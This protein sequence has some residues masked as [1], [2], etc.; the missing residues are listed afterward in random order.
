MGI[1]G[2]GIEEF[3]EFVMEFVKEVGKK[4]FV[5]YGKGKFQVKFDQGMVIEVELCLMDFFQEK[6]VESYL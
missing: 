6:F 2:Y 4:V 5:F 3:S 1:K